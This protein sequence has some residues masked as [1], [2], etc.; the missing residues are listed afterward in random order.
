MSKKK[1][2]TPL[3]QSARSWQDWNM[4]KTAAIVLA[5][6]KGTRMKS[7]LPKVLMP[8][9]KLC[10]SLGIHTA[11]ELAVVE[12]ELGRMSSNSPNP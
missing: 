8:V 4:N 1:P 10:E 11:A 5:A 12:T 7:E 2:T 6:G 3:E 9:L